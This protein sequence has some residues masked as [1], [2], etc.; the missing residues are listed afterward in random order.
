MNLFLASYAFSK[1]LG[2]IYRYVVPFLLIE[3]GSVLV[4]TY[5]PWLTTVLLGI[6]K[7]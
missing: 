5:V 1:P 7:L 6:L 2:T 4:I 3:L